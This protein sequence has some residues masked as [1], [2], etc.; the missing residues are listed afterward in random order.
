M[1]DRQLLSRAETC[2]AR[3]L[4]GLKE[5]TARQITEALPAN[6]RRDFSTVQTYLTRLESK[7]YVRSQLV[8]R[9]KI[10]RPIIKPTQVI[11]DTVDDLVDRLFEGQAYPLLKHLVED[12]KV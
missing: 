2:V 3:V 11:R 10:F 7:G 8:G 1:A 9:T 4:W 12:R 6:Q 5:A